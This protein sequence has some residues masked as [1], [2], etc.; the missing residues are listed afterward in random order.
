MGSPHINSSQVK[1][2][3][4]TDL[5]QTTVISWYKSH[6]MHMLLKIGD[7]GEPYY[8]LN[9]YYFFLIYHLQVKFCLVLKQFTFISLI[10][11]VVL[12]IRPLLLHIKNLLTRCEH[13]KSKIKNKKS[14]SAQR[15]WVSH[16]SHK[17]NHQKYKIKIKCWCWSWQ[18][19][20]D[21]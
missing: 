6:S 5:I 12:Q 7:C 16:L 4:W 2:S 20:W 17:T 1:G 19:C 15:L 13:Y 3:W 14:V 21:M 11:Y 18:K 9:L 10:K 8:N